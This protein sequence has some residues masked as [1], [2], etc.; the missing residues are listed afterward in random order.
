MEIPPPFLCFK[1]YTETSN[2]T[3]DVVDQPSTACISVKWNKMR[4]GKFSF[5]FIFQSIFLCPLER[6]W[7]HKWPVTVFNVL[8]SHSNIF[9]FFY[10]EG[11]NQAIYK[12]HKTQL[13]E[14]LRNTQE[15]VETFF[16]EFFLFFNRCLILFFLQHNQFKRNYWRRLLKAL[17]WGSW[18]MLSMNF[19]CVLQPT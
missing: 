18:V 16:T 8:F 10:P 17:M 14:M 11:G 3:V 13:G 1:A 12:I 19:Y 7:H 6:I 2:N 4:W 5:F 9:F 15:I